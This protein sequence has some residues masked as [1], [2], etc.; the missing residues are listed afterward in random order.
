[1]PRYRPTSPDCASTQ[2]HSTASRQRAS[3]WQLQLEAA[4][5][6]NTY[7][8]PYPGLLR[9][10]L[11]AGLI[12]AQRRHEREQASQLAGVSV[13]PNL[14][15]GPSPSF[16]QRAALP[17]LDWSSST[18]CPRQAAHC[19]SGSN[20]LKHQVP[21]LAHTSGFL[22]GKA[23][24]ITVHVKMPNCLRREEIPTRLSPAL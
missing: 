5:P 21:R 3:N 11:H 12:P 2:Q 19:I 24:L 10:R 6:L 14:E 7:L 9:Q 15:R 13:P 4:H 18:M 23:L 17:K 1:M 16:I 20:R 22:R 8:V